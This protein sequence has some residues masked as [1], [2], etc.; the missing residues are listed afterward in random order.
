M[1]I[2]E[3]CSGREWPGWLHAPRSCWRSFAPFS[4]GLLFASFALTVEEPHAEAV[5]GEFP[6]TQGLA[7][8]FWFVANQ[9]LGV[10]FARV[11][12][13]GFRAV[14]DVAIEVGESIVAIKCWPSGPDMV[15]L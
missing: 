14:R 15:F 8:T 12:D 11:V 5:L 2:R 4:G 3:R 13:V 10:V 6:R 7:G 1:S 9:E